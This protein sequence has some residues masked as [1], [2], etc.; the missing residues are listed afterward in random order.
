MKAIRTSQGGHITVSSKS[1]RLGSL[2]PPYEPS[3]LGGTPPDPRARF[4][5]MNLIVVAFGPSYGLDGLGF[6]RVEV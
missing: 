3:F 5:R 2:G 4:A 6:K 1:H